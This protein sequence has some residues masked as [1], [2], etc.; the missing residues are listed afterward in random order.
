MMKLEQIRNR[1]NPRHSGDRYRNQLRLSVRLLN[2]AAYHE[3]DDEVMA[4]AKQL[5]LLID[6]KYPQILKD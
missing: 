6:E 3:S 2:E 5:S 4:I 1:L